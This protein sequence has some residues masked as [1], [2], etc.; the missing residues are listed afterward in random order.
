M[1]NPAKYRDQKKWMNDCMHQMH[2]EHKDKEH[3]LAQC[4]NQWR[5]K[6]KKCCLADTLKD[7]GASM[8]EGKYIREK[9]K[10]TPGQ[11]G[12]K[13]TLWYM[14]TPEGKKVL[15]DQKSVS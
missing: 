13:P 11:P 6:G 7:I 3:A 12:Y 4:L 8:I 15:V 1:P 14:I 2:I 10:G 9:G 5:Q